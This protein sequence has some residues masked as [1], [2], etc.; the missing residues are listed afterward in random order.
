M[1]HRID[2]GER[3]RVDKRATGV[4]KCRNALEVITLTDRN[5]RQ[6]RKVV[7]KLSKD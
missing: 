2:N 1:F 7:R 3:E 4:I 6:G 5:V